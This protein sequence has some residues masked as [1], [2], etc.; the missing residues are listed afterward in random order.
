MNELEYYS[1]H[2]IATIGQDISNMQLHL[3]RRAR[4]YELVGIPTR[5]LLKADVLEVGAGGGYNALAL[6]LFGANVDIVE[7]NVRACEDAEKLF[8]QFK[9]PKHQY[10]IFNCLV[11]EYQNDKMY[12]FIGAE[13]FLP[14]LESQEVKENVVQTMKNLVK[15][16]G[17][18]LT[19]SMCEIG[20]AFEDFRRILGLRLI[21][22][23]KAMQ[24]QI[25]ILAC[26]F[27]SHLKACKFASKP[28]KDWVVA[29]ILNPG[30][31]ATFSTLA[32][33]TEMF[34]KENH[35]EVIGMSPNAIPNLS[36]YRNMD[37]QYHRVICDEFLS[38]EHLFLSNDIK[39][40][41]REKSKNIC[42]RERLKAMRAHIKI[43]KDSIVNGSNLCAGGGAFL[44]IVEILEL[45]LQEND[46][47]K[48]RFI[49]SVQEV[50]TLLKGEKISPQ[51]VANMRFKEAWG[52][53]Q[54][55]I[56]FKRV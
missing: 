43:I 21:C 20:Y 3:K 39:D 53:G 17:N 34:C 23:I 54:Q 41:I 22:G 47:I 7:P 4:L 18:I 15:V 29:T 8:M 56:N 51:Q 55:Y 33:I 26:A 46:D 11:E 2:N 24:E 1:L 16:N 45:I 42:L 36:W 9:I 19:T 49:P 13:G 32:D 6:L 12:D 27:E 10:R 28:I 25:E 30:L 37:Y 44:P 38:K 40:S 52:Q 50:I 31:D 48:G 35:C 5:A 14:T